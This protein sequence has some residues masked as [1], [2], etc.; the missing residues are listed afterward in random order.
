MAEAA[1]RAVLPKAT[2]SHPVPSSL[3]LLAGLRSEGDLRQ[4]GS[5]HQQ[6]H[7]VE[8]ILARDAGLSIILAFDVC[9]HLNETTCRGVRLLSERAAMCNDLRVHTSIRI[10]ESISLGK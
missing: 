2:D 6:Q 5:H 10:A 8:P 4:Q 7:I 3:K 1:R 9:L